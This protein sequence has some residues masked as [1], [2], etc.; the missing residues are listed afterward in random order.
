LVYFFLERIDFFQGFFKLLFTSQGFRYPSSS[1]LEITAEGGC[2]TFKR[3]NYPQ[4][5]L[6]GIDDLDSFDNL[7]GV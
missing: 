6:E 1:A 4:L 7:S 3:E 5:P 2:A